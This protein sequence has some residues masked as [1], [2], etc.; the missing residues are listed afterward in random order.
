MPV[1]KSWDE[2]EVALLIEAYFEIKRANTKKA[3]VLSSLSE[4]LRKRAVNLGME[5]DDT[6]RN[7]NGMVWQERYIAQA[8][9]SS[10][11]ESRTPSALFQK[12]T[13]LYRDKPDEFKRILAVAKDQVNGVSELNAENEICQLSFNEWLIK[14]YGN[15]YSAQSILSAL[16]ET[17]E[18]AISRKIT[19]DRLSDIDDPIAFNKI[20]HTILQNRFFRLMH[21]KAAKQLD[22]TAQVYKKYL[23]EKTSCIGKKSDA[24]ETAVESKPKSPTGNSTDDK[25]C[26][27]LKASFPYGI[28][29]S[30]VRDLMR[31]R[32]AAE[33]A[34]VELPESDEELKN[35]LMAS[36]TM[37][38]DKIF[39]KSE[40]MEGELK[41]KIEAIFASGVNIIYYESLF[42][43]EQEWM[44]Q[45]HITSEEI[46]K[47]TLKK[48]IPE[49]IYTRIFFAKSEKKTEYEAL[50]EE[51]KRIWGENAVAEITQLSKELPYVPQENIQRVLFAT[52]H[53][54]WVS[55]GNYLLVDR[56]TISEQ[57]EEA[58]LEYVEK[59]CDE[60]GYASLTD[61]PL[62]CIQ[63]NNSF[64]SGNALYAAIYN[65]ILSGKYRNNG[66]ILTTGDS[67]INI[68]SLLSREFCDREEITFDEVNNRVTELNGGTKR[69]DSFE[70]LY[71]NFVRISEEDFVAPKKLHFDVGEIDRV[72]SDI[73][74]DGFGAIKDVTT[75]AM[76]PVCG[77]T[78]NHYVLESYCYRYSQKYY[79][80]IL[81]FNSKNAGII[82][83][84]KSGYSYDQM[85]AM[86]LAEASVDL[87]ETDAGEYLFQ[88]GMMAKRK[89]AKLGEIISEAERIRK[90]K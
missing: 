72:L 37:M 42:Y 75:F 11:Y 67:T 5:I 48:K 53:F 62:G 74:H 20:I 83:E 35:L 89:Y 45:N 6:F 30:S 81:N 39:A 49:Y 61:I 71:N 41:E 70:I 36:G 69:Q 65:K 88:R 56:V 9:N 79:L 29:I 15:K 24:L 78:W 54:V 80:S 50:S 52:N 57:E 13:D 86:A 32:L 60:T 12:M 46:L 31:F 59:S 17:E 44:E 76:F 8:F 22:K 38:D 19:K 4:Q 58:I 68:V 18:Y 73:Y 1:Q 2:Y 84:K 14:Y 55:E 25:I 23:E 40:N 21:S 34:T 26:A 47:D 64:V 3:A 63:D 7:I 87:N 85:L 51:I 27:L 90:E 28:R 16:K 33:E 10:R 43:A 66:K 82:G 77:T